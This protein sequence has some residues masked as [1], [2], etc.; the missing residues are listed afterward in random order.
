MAAPT[1]SPELQGSRRYES[2]RADPDEPV[3]VITID[4]AGLCLRRPDGN[5]VSVREQEAE[6]L[7]VWEHDQRTLIGADGATIDINP[8]WWHRGR[9]LLRDIDMLVPADR[10]VR[11]RDKL[12]PPDG[13]PN[14]REPIRLWV[15]LLVS[16]AAVVLL[17]A[18][19]RAGSGLGSVVYAGIVIGF[20]APL[21]R[22]LQPTRRARGRPLSGWPR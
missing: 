10:Q 18:M 6:A 12:D 2:R 19:G 5:F 11:M 9:E 15:M 3:A 1:W 14:L 21:V 7:L 22:Q 20:S 8:A 4:P 16:L 17:F 13:P